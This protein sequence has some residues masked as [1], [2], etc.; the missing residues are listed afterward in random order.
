MSSKP[1]DR[2]A[3]FPRLRGFALGKRFSSGT[4]S[5]SICY[6]VTFLAAIVENG[7][8]EDLTRSPRRIPLAR[9][10]GLCF[11]GER[12]ERRMARRTAN[13]A[14]SRT[15]ASRAAVW[16]SAT[17][18]IWARSARPR[19][20]LGASRSKCSTRTPAIRGRW[21]CFLR[22]APPRSRPTVRSCSF[23]CQT[24]GYVDHDK[25]VRADWPGGCGE[26]C[27]GSCRRIAKGT[28]W[29]Q[30]LKVLAS[31]RLITLGSKWKL[32]RDWFAPS[33]MADLSP[34]W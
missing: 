11:C 23:A 6:C 5:R 25:G 20:R 2:C 3:Y 14:S 17:F 31:Y 21:R 9:F 10:V 28:R 7:C 8:S 24:R 33:G 26:S 32:H 27:S 30:V 1:V 18:C 19:S 12:G 22:I 34:I 13:G 4:G 29:D 15:S 16:C